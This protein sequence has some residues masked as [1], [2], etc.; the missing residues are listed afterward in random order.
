MKTCATCRFWS[1]PDYDPAPRWPGWVDKAAKQGYGECDCF[2]RLDEDYPHNNQTDAALQV[3]SDDDSGLT[4]RFRTKATFGCMTHE[5]AG[6]D[7]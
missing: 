6:Q 7:G 1:A 4:A 3:E 2:D 5:E